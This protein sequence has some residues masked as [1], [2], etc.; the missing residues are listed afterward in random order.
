MVYV[1]LGTGVRG[2]VTSNAI[3]LLRAHGSSVVPLG[4]LPSAAANLWA[5]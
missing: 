2:T 1:R 4:H 3:G 5:L